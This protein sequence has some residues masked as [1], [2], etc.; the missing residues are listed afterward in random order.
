MRF[1]GRT[2]S[3]LSPTKVALIPWPAKSPKSNRVVVPELP[4]SNGSVGSENF[5]PF[6]MT[7]FLSF[8]I[9]IPQASKH[10]RV[11]CTSTPVDRFEILDSPSANAAN[12]RAR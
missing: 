3:D 2:E 5:L 1:I 8:L 12:I 7:S 9:L 4:Q 6:T 11:D 10:F